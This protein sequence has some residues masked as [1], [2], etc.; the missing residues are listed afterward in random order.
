M[1]DPQNL[2]ANSPPRPARDDENV[3]NA[4]VV[5]HYAER[6]GWGGKTYDDGSPYTA[7]WRAADAILRE[8]MNALTMKAGIG[9][10]FGR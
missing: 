2:F 6:D 7:L 1:G 10:Y 3:L 9:G 8:R 4:L 5:M